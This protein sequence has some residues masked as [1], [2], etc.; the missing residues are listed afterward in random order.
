MVLVSAAYINNTGNIYFDASGSTAAT[1]NTSNLIVN[2]TLTTANFVTPTTLNTTNNLTV[3]GDFNLNGLNIYGGKYLP[4]DVIDCKFKCYYDTSAIT[5]F[6]S[7]L[8]GFAGFGPIP[9][10]PGGLGPSTFTRLPLPTC[11]VNV[12]ELVYWGVD[13]NS[14]STT[15]MSATLL[16]P[17]TIQSSTIV[18][19]KHGTTST[20]WQSA[21]LWKLLE[22][23]LAN[24]L[25][26]STS[27]PLDTSPFLLT[28]AP[29]VV[30]CAD[31][32]GYGIG[33]GI[34]N[35]NDTPT[36]ASSQYYATVATGKLIR[37]KPELFNGFTVPEGNIDVINGGYSVG[38]WDAP[39][40]AQ[41]IQANPENGLRCINNVIGAPA[42]VFAL[43]TQMMSIY[44]TLKTGFGFVV[45]VL[46]TTNAVQPVIQTNVLQPNIYTDVIPN[47]NSFYVN[48]NPLTETF[49]DSSNFNGILANSLIE[50]ITTNNPGS[51]YLPEYLNDSSNYFYPI[52]VFDLSGYSA[53]KNKFLENGSYYTNKFVN[54]SDLSGVPMNV[55]YSLQDQFCCYDPTNGQSPYG[56]PANDTVNPYLLGF[57]TDSSFVNVFGQTQLSPANNLGLTLG[58]TYNVDTSNF[59]YTPANLGLCYSSMANI[60]EASETDHTSTT[61]RFNSNLGFGDQTYQ[62]HAGFGITYAGTFIN[63][64]N[65]RL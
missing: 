9:A 24:N 10:I 23:F 14:C 35:Y 60:I 30:V 26:A 55:L 52:T 32:P 64:L 50:S 20:T 21:T 57:M 44:P 1:L 17:E 65:N 18:S 16:V 47:F 25:K 31:N 51:P 3:D 28:L 42:N 7:T 49:M 29:Y 62:G 12:Y 19:Q 5:F 53:Y 41:L 37:M 22:A 36:E 6:W 11:G 13:Q 33:G 43:Y 15:R 8:P 46:R 54:Y 39:Y 34:L 48:S 58:T 56:N 4:G 40:V 63:Y 38:G 2:G 61:M 27:L 59:N 45:N